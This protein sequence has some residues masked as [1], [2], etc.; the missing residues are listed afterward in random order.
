ME[1]PGR[2][3]GNTLSDT[4]YDCKVSEPT[5]LRFLRKIDFTSYQLFKISLAKN[6]SDNTSEEVYEDVTFRD[7]TEQIVVKKLFIQL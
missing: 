7:T 3:I 1:D 2:V 6:Y 5:V 4:A